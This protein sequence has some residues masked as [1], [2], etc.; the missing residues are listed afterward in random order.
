MFPRFKNQTPFEALLA[1]LIVYP[2]FVIAFI[3][4]IPPIY[5]GL[6]L[7]MTAYGFLKFDFSGLEFS[8]HKQWESIKH[9]FKNFYFQI[10]TVQFIGNLEAAEETFPRTQWGEDH[11]AL[12]FVRVIDYSKLYAL[13]KSVI[14]NAGEDLTK[15]F[16]IVLG[17]NSS[18][19]LKNK[20]SDPAMRSLAGE[21]KDMNLEL[22][23]ARHLRSALFYTSE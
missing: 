15:P 12:A 21:L 10:T 7:F 6:N 3:V 17:T 23:G 11:E 5:I 20:I 4:I 1:V 19:A 14:D 2:L 18:V 13:P 22:L 9:M 8:L 16:V